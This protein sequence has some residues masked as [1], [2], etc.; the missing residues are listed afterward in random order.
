M[1]PAA[2]KSLLKNIQL[3][4]AD[5]DDWLGE[6]L[7]FN[8]EQMGFGTVRRVRSGQDAYTALAR[9][10]YDFVIT[11]WNLP[12][13]DGLSL[14]RKLRSSKEEIIRPALPVIMLSGRSEKQ[15]VLTARD[16]GINEYIVKPFSSQAVFQRLERLVDQPRPFII[17][18]QFSGPDRRRKAA[19]SGPDKRQRS[20]HLIHP[21][22]AA[23]ALKAGVACMLPPDYSVSKALNNTPLSQ[24]ITPEILREA[25]ETLDQMAGQGAEWV[26]LD[27]AMLQEAHRWLQNKPEPAPLA[28][29]A[30]TALSIKGRAGLAGFPLAGDVARLL[31]LFINSHYRPGN[32]THLQILGKHIDVMKVI[33]AA[34]MPM[35]DKAGS[36]IIG[37]LQRLALSA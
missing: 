22:E 28:R 1:T 10:P 9:K 14:V 37:E 6:A 32:A 18:P 16:A 30:D 34:A 33:F 4:I 17:S 36:E 20:P 11:E 12:E 15:D 21:S 35:N 24:I 13:M 19:H 8:L 31:Y 25:Q 2:R 5:A 3:L 27:L 26:L 7:R 29:M 23:R